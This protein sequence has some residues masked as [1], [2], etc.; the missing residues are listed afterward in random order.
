VPLVRLS[1]VD[2]LAGRRGWCAHVDVSEAWHESSHTDV[3]PG[4]PYD[5]WTKLL[6]GAAPA[7]APAP[8]PA[9]AGR[10]A[11]AG[12]PPIIAWPL[13]PGEWFGNWRGG[14]K[15]HGGFYAAE[16]GWVRNIQQWLI[17]RGCTPVSYNQWASS[18]WAD[19]L[20]EAATD[21][22]M[23]QFHRRFYPGQPYPG[24]CWADDYRRLT[25]H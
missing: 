6:T 16:R 4:F 19:G 11:P 3:G 24:Q 23:A 7:P 10:P 15:Q 13:K 17:Y 25:A 5:E 1:P 8:A 14:E 21:E 20:W 18:R 22:A 9:A 2:L 12:R